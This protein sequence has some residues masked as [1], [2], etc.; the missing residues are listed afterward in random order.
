VAQ[1]RTIDV[2]FPRG[3]LSKRFAYQQQPPYTTLS[4]PNTRPEGVFER[5]LRGGSRPGILKSFTADAD[6]LPLADGNGDPIRLLAV[7]RSLNIEGRATFS[8]PFDDDPMSSTNWEAASWADDGLFD[9][10]AVSGRA[11]TRRLEERGAVLKTAVSN[12]L[13]ATGEYTI[14]IKLLGA[15]ADP[16]R[17][18]VLGRGEYV[19]YK[20]FAKL[21]D[22]TPLP[23]TSICARLMYQRHA[24]SGDYRA[25]L[26]IYDDDW[27]AL[28]DVLFVNQ[29]LDAPG[30]FTFQ[31]NAD[32]TATATWQSAGLTKS[33]SANVSGCGSS[34]KRIA[35]E[36]DASESSVST[37]Y[38]LDEF[39][40]RY[41]LAAA[42]VPPEAVIA[43]ANGK[44]YRESTEGS[45]VEITAQGPGV[46]AAE[47]LMAVD[48]LGKLYIADHGNRIGSVASTEARQTD[49]A[50]SS[51]NK[52]RLTSNTIDTSDDDWTKFGIDANGDWLEIMA[53][54]TGSAANKAAAIGLHRVAAQANAGYLELA[55]ALSID[56]NISGITFRVARGPKVYDSTTDVLALWIPTAG[57]IPLGCTILEIFSDR[58]VFGGDPE[59]PGIYYMSRSADFDDFDY[60]AS[61][62]DRTRAIS[63]LTTTS[64]GG[65]LSTP[66]TAIAAITEDYCLFSGNSEFFLLRGDPTLGGIMANVSRQIGIGSR[67]AWCR[68][69]D[70][71]VVFM[72]RDGVYKFHPSNPF[73]VNISRDNLP[74]DL[75]DVVQNTDLTVTLEYDVRFEG[76]H[77]CVTP[78][79]AGPTMHYWIHWAT[80]AFCQAP[81]EN[82]DH[83]PFS[84]T[85]D[86]RANRVLFGCRDGYI[87]HH[88]AAAADDDGTAIKSHVLY[89]PFNL[90]GNVREG[91]IKDVYV[92]LD[93]Q[94]GDAV[95][96][97][98]V[99]DDPESAYKSA[100]FISRAVSAGYSNRIPVR[101]R[102][103]AAFVK[104][105]DSSG[106][107]W[108]IDSLSLVVSRNGKHRG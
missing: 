80:Q 88:S 32:G 101:A 97:V 21:S 46:N 74:L 41:I 65:Q 61:V 76:V 55:S 82:T 18:P 78:A 5:R 84:V 47:Q 83:D 85:Y 64:D 104:I 96:E 42:G 22:T 11:R 63:D 35:V 92:V 103:S 98:F 29:R 45:I 3:G 49:G 108:A 54:A 94:S 7:M 43:V 12:L 20:L 23:T 51:D 19:Y 50:V 2:Q 66:F 16:T 70:G 79:T 25:W 89:G 17:L 69:P 8:E 24:T 6:E 27:T 59:H 72:S 60:S 67:T 77:I 91:A 62:T 1:T 86:A 48:R 38:D 34:G 52:D 95:V 44:V 105:S 40:L 81:L 106:S 10:S 58:A 68:I 102:G 26:G 37:Y 99:G 107:Q 9:T 71:S 56:A 93:D 14:A 30:Y 73:P 15:T 28:G 4:A 87:R 33:V 53:V 75:I 90:G 100:P 57:S 36:V 31:V 13:T 39:G